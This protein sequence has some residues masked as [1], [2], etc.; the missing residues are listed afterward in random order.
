MKESPNLLKLK[1]NGKTVRT[2]NDILIGHDPAVFPC[3]S[4]GSKFVFD[5]LTVNCVS[6]VRFE[7]E[8]TKNIT[9]A[10]FD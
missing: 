2:A 1:N 3:F 5:A 10:A 9:L 4:A 6:L 7:I 8:P